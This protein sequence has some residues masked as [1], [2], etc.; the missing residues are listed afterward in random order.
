MTFGGTSTNRGISVLD[1]W[2]P[3][4]TNTRV[5]ALTVSDNNNETR[6]STYYVEDGSYLKLKYIKLKYDFPTAWTKKFGAS[7]LS[8]FGQV[9]NLFTITS[10][11]GLDPE[12]PL[13]DYGARV[14][15]APYPIARTFSMGVNLN[16]NL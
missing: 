9:E 4:H 13:G 16:F 6:M 2:T 8:I 14:D 15:S 7:A 11:S 5:P 10:Y 12:L 1:A 3:T